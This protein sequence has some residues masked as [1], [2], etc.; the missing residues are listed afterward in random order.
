MSSRAT[1]DRMVMDSIF[2]RIAYE[3]DGTDIKIILHVQVVQDALRGRVDIDI[4]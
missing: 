2:F 3:Q 4:S 1:A